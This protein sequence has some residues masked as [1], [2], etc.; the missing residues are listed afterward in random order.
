MR[1][2]KNLPGA[3]VEVRA[4]PIAGPPAPDDTGVGPGSCMVEFIFV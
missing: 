3:V 4:G 1:V 2:L